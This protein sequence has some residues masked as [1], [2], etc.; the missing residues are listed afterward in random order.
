M[1]DNLILRWSLG[2]QDTVLLSDHTDFQNMLWLTK[3]SIVSFQ[4]WFPKASFMMFYNGNHFQDFVKTLE[5]IKPYFLYSVQYVDQVNSLREGNLVNPYHYYPRGVWWKWI[6]FR[7][8]INRHEISIDTDIICLGEPHT[9]YDWLESKEEIIVAPERFE[10]TKQG[11]CGDFHGHPIL[12]GKKPLNCGV[13][14][15]RAGHDFSDRFFEITKSVDFGRTHDS[16]FITEQGAINVWAYSLAHEKVANHYVLD[17]QKN[18][19]IRDFVY[20]MEKGVT[21]ETVHAVTWH[22]KIAKA[23]G[24][25]FEKRVCDMLYN[26]EEFLIDILEVVKKLDYFSRRLITRQIGTE[27]QKETEFL[28][29]SGSF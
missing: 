21:I 17:F 5:S 10:E 19:W 22:K 25:I 4:R 20:F 28:F 29:R 26:E 6:P 1:Y 12:R 24:S 8:D 7:Y 11:T 2:K 14:G 15:H 9:W 16:Q 18:A 3:L 27:R 13:V 23:L